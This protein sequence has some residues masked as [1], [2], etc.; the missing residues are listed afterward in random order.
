MFYNA[1]WYDPYI[2]Q[3]SQPDTIVP[4][5][6]NPQAW[7]RYAYTLNNPLRYVDP[8]GHKSCDDI[9]GS[10]SC[11]NY[12]NNLTG[13]L[14][15][16]DIKILTAITAME[17]S[18][19]NVPNDVNYLKAWALLNARSYN[20]ANGNFYGNAIVDWKHHER[21]L[22]NSLGITGTI[23]EQEDAILKWY[24]GAANGDKSISQE[25]FAEL[26]SSVTKAVNDWALYGSKSSADPV[27][28]ATG[29]VDASGLCYPT[30]ACSKHG[31]NWQ[32]FGDM[33]NY[34]AVSTDV[35]HSELES[36]RTNIYPNSS[37]IYSTGIYPYTG[38]KMYT[39]TWFEQP[40]YPWP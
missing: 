24:D 27:H 17:S 32:H 33:P 23:E 13:G 5:L 29:F 15:D 12:K 6:N 9:N 38:L 10:G 18:S 1:R 8:S 26:E 22:L 14:S 19:G 16:R 35:D 39:F 3:F 11:I 7:D 28:G 34:Y 30:G 37:Q 20:R 2:T 40:S 21:D 36:W 25:D 31:G 4:D